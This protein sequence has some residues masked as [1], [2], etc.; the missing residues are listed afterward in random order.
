MCGI[1]GI[2][3]FE[4]QYG[5]EE[6]RRFAEAMADTLV[7]RGPDD[8]GGW[9]SEDGRCAL[10]HRRLS[11][12]E[13]SP[14]GRQPMHAADGRAVIS[15]NGEIYNYRELRPE[16]EA[17]GRALRTR[18][19]TEVL[20][21]AVREWG[22]LAFPRIDG[23]YAFAL[24]EQDRRALWLARDPFGE[25]PLY[26]LNDGKRLAFASELHALQR[27]PFFDGAVT[28][29][30][31]AEY[32]CFG[33]LGAPRTLYRS[34]AK[35]PPGSYLRIDASGRS[36]LQRYFEFQPGVDPGEPERSLDDLADELQ[37]ILVRLVRRR[38][39]SDV[40]L[41]A[42]LSGGVDSSTVCALVRKKLGVPL[43]TF[44][45]GFAGSAESEHEQ[46]RRYADYLETQHHEQQV[47]P[48]AA[49]FL[50]HAGERFDEP[51]GDSSCLPTILLSRFA[52]ERVTVAVSGDGGDEMF[53]GYGRYFDALHRQARVRRRGRA[54][55]LGR[56]Y[57]DGV[58][59]FRDE[60]LREL[61]GRVPGELAYHLER[62][63]AFVDLDYGRADLLM[64][65]RKTD[66]D[67]YLPGAVLAKVDRMSM[68]HALEVR[69][70]FLS[71]EL[72]RFA[73]RLPTS[74]LYRDGQ[75]KLLLKH[76]AARFLP[77]EWL[78]LPK[79]GFGL[80]GRAWGR[81]ELLDVVSPLLESGDSA[82]AG[83]LGRDRVAR[84][85][86]RQRDPAR[87]EIYPLWAIGILESYLRARPALLPRGD[88]VPDLV[89]LEVPAVHPLSARLAEEAGRRGGEVVL[90]CGES[91]P[92]WWR[93]IP[94]KVT[95]VFPL[96]VGASG[97]ARV[98][99]AD[100]ARTDG[101][102][103]GALEG[104]IARGSIAAFVSAEAAA[105]LTPAYCERLA[106]LG[107]D[108][109]AVGAPDEAETA[110]L[111]LSAYG[112]FAR[113][114]E[115]AWLAP[116]RR[117]G[118][119]GNRW[120]AG[121][122][123]LFH[124]RALPRGSRAADGADAPLAVVEGRR[125][126]LVAG[127]TSE[128]VRDLGAGRHRVG[129]ERVW[130]SATDDS[131]PR[132]N[133]RAYRVVDLRERAAAPWW[134]PAPSDAR[135]RD[136]VLQWLSEPDPCARPPRAPH[137]GDTVALV[138]QTLFA[139]GAEREWVQLGRELVARGFRVVLFV[140]TLDRDNAHYLP[141]AE[142]ASLEVRD[143]SR[144]SSLA[145]PPLPHDALDPRVPALIACAP[146]YLRRDL[147]RLTREL[148]AI[149]ADFVAC[150][151]DAPNVCGGLAGLFAGARR[152]LL[153][154]RNQNPS[155]MPSLFAPWL[156]DYYRVLA[157][158]QRIAFTGNS[159]AG[160]D[161]YAGWLGIDAARIAAIHNG[162][163]PEPF[164]SIGGR[165]VAELRASLG[166]PP[167]ARVVCGL[168]RWSPEK[169]PDAFLEVSRRLVTARGDVVVVQAGGGPLLDDA[170]RKVRELGL[171]QRIRVLGRRR[172]PGA[173]LRASQL[174]LMTSLVE[175][176]P[177]ALLE[178][179][180]LGVPVVATT[181]GGTGEAVADGETG[182]L[183]PPRDVDALTRCCLELLDDPERRRRMG[184][185][186]RARMEQRFS[187]DALVD[188]T[189][190]ALSAP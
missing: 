58:R 92:T 91:C 86:A 49:H 120:H 110:V 18:T 38:L 186:G 129:A 4:R 104:E 157:H 33:Y 26:Y 85:L 155:L 189:L 106:S 6:M 126:L 148:R 83:A 102:G 152:V 121:G 28:E 161:D 61:F 71:I 16:L 1:A 79:R 68:Q 118:G 154:F 40:P 64:R 183:N 80:P 179:Q 147:W 133:R 187:I 36:S 55:E 95:F 8:S 116:G 17:R 135:H 162:F 172:D 176:L 150:Q 29:E 139:G 46:A 53:G 10:A 23:M 153:S 3:Q 144:P 132:R 180:F 72:A 19:D 108:A 109:A 47:A 182:L 45:I 97:G 117:I 65:L 50:R 166:I 48:D 60:L 77:R 175:G 43:E 13:P 184:D 142:R 181:A 62:L 145:D 178:A 124:A 111:D 167:D 39:I 141:L 185:A 128:E 12:I 88:R 96:A 20:I 136:A 125:P 54:P 131:D 123:H 168:F 158:S 22:G 15:F 107:F 32:L 99:R 57:Y 127:A 137:A 69:T 119:R 67:H 149:S 138:T 7:H 63:R 190:A 21:E 100:W 34:A 173:L 51:N 89:D 35:L 87:T 5:P 31:L 103:L 165:E 76:L 73:E 130:I 25:K 146:E 112:A 177:N 164:A 24:Y 44:S 174:A 115:R 171:E 9:V 101:A 94:A 114:C 30:G 122:G 163:D 70:P 41:G 66:V 170:R 143:L 93:A 27:L 113:A 14:V 105:L 11:I 188:A 84:F 140:S 59:V 82:L 42:F 37:E 160:N 156:R 78:D 159:R 56:R 74:A 98:L 81:S 134:G 151:L 2:L 169:D 75:G 52:R 90:F